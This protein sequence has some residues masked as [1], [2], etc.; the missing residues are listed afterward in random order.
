MSTGVAPEDSR[1]SPRH[2]PGV[3][4][5]ASDR[6]REIVAERVAA[7][8]PNM[9]L[10]STYVPP[11]GVVAAYL[12][13]RLLSSGDTTGVAWHSVFVNSGVEALGTVAKYLRNRH[14][15]R[16]A[17]GHC[18]ILVLD[19]TGTAYYAFG[20]AVPG[21]RALV[22]DGM[23]IVGSAAEFSGLL[24]TGWDSY[25]VVLDGLSAD[26]AAALRGTLAAERAKGRPVAWGLLG[27]EGALARWRAAAT[28]ADLAFLGE[29][30]V[31]NE[32]PCGTVS[33]TRDM[34]ALWNNSMDSIAHVSTFGGNGRIQAVV[35]TVGGLVGLDSSASSASAGLAQLR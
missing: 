23:R 2:I 9:V 30:C 17:A 27:A 4:P 33:F 34:F 25:V 13:H 20:H 5:G 6:V 15:R 22:A 7:R 24:G 35:A 21:L 10:A 1:G 18:R 32:M 29:V 26:E 14:N 19:P 11:D 12:L 28:C 31:G 3:F 8:S 16:A